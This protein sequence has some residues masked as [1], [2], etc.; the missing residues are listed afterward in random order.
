[1]TGALLVINIFLFY[2]PAWNG[3]ILALYYIFTQSLQQTIHRHEPELAERQR[4]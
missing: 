3:G 2:N 4:R 1:M